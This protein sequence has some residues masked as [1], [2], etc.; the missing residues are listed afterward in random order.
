MVK[1]AIRIPP[2]VKPAQAYEYGVECGEL[3]ATVENCHFSIFSTPENTK[4]WERGKADGEKA[5][6]R[7]DKARS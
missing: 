1:I 4:E 7:Q 6:A 2:T 5:R 3:G